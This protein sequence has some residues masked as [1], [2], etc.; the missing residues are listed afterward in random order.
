MFKKICILFSCILLTLTL[1]GCSTQP[2]PT[3]IPEPTREPA[4]IYN[5]GQS[6]QADLTRFS[7][8]K[9][10][11][12]DAAVDKAH[13]VYGI[14]IRVY[15]MDTIEIPFDVANVSCYA[16]EGLCE[17]YSTEI[18]HTIIAPHSFV[19]GW[20]YYKIPAVH[21]GLSFTYTYNKYG[22]YVL[23]EFSEG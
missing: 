21:G 3:P 9:S 7:I 23:F 18:E 13:V 15:N 5:V 11:R 16:G 12:V 10:G 6:F 1:V 22:D 4:A 14:Y 19:E 17:I 20:I 2:A 8:L